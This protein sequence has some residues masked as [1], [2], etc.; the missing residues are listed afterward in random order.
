MSLRAV[1]L[2]LFVEVAL[3][4]GLLLWLAVLRRDDLVSGA[5]KPSQI[6]LRERH[7]PRRTLQVGN[8][9][10]NQFELPL[11]FYLL[12]VLEIITRHA[13]L[14]FVVLA[15]V[16]VLTRLVHAFIHTTS[17]RVTQRGAIYGVGVFVLIVMW[18]IFMVRILVGWP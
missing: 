4:L 16:F 11:L 12:A 15:W 5:V 14:L 9:F 2:P 8:A 10:S 1:L 18:L 3:T 13:D 17:N 6:A 7:W